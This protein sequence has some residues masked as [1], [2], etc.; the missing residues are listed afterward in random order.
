MALGA[1][2]IAMGIVRAFMPGSERQPEWY[3]FVSP[4]VGVV[5]VTLSALLFPGRAAG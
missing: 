5:G 2:V 3:T 4:L 1:V